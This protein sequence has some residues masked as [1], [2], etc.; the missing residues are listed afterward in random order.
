MCDDDIE[1]LIGRFLNLLSLNH[2]RQCPCNGVGEISACNR[3]VVIN[4]FLKFVG[5]GERANVANSESFL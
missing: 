3:V 5:E 1:I 2:V 4:N